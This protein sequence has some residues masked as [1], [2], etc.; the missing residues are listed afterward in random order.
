MQ[1]TSLEGTKTWPTIS[2]SY[3]VGREG[4]IAIWSRLGE[5]KLL[6][7]HALREWVAGVSGLLCQ[8]LAGPCFLC[9]L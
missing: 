9:F 8:Q 2:P 1:R 5:S 4:L 6:Y 7:R 3:S